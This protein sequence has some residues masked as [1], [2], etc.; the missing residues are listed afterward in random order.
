MTTFTIFF[1]GTGSTKYDNL[2][3]N[4]WNGELVATLANNIDGH[5]FAEWIVIDGPGSGN[6]QADEL[7]T[8]SKGFGWTGTA[9]GKGWHENV[10][11][12]VNIIQGK[13]DWQRT[14][15]SEA[16]YQR[17][18]RADV[19]IPDAQA[20][21]SWFWRQ[22][23]Y[24]NRISPQELQR[25]LIKNLRKDGLI[26][27]QINL[28]GWSRGG[29]SCHML[30]NA[31]MANPET[32]QIPVNIFAVDP[33]P[34]PLNYQLEKVSLGSNVKEYVAF[35]ARDERS[36]GFSCIIPKTDAR[37][38]VSIFPMAGRHAS[39]V[40]NASLTGASGPG[41]LTE[42]GT[43]VRHYAEVCLSR[44]GTKLQRKLNLS[45][46]DVSRLHQS[47]VMHE[48]DFIKMR[49]HSYTVLREDHKTERYVSYADKGTGFSMVAGTPFKPAQGLAATL[50]KGNEAYNDIC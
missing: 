17:L 32:R 28:V 21:G 20:H 44:W 19:P 50:A 8:E 18:K 43:I 16:D 12:A 3:K 34:G 26:P 2:H 29:V 33:V 35:Y 11:H 42:P 22:Y 39:L 10:Q 30:A 1:C 49:N 48:A 6:M 23:D 9:F 37:T 5:E 15:L 47:V 7:F 24:G 25:Q 13:F 14:K 46:T 31:L 36:K 4:Y 40:G 41:D 38:K 45:A 27:K